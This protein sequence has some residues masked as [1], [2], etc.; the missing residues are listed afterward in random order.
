MSIYDPKKYTRV[1]WIT[2]GSTGIGAETA[3]RLAQDGWVVA[4]SARS[5]DKLVET[6]KRHSN[7]HVFPLDVTKI[8]SVTETIDKIEDQFGDIK[9]AIL[10]AGTYVPDTLEDFNIKNFKKHFDINVIGV[11][12]CVEPLLKKFKERDQGHLAITASIA[13]YHGLP[14]SL[15]YGPTKAA[16]IN[17]TESLK[18]ETKGTNIKVQ[19][20]CPGFVKTPLT[21]QNEFSMPM[22]METDKAAEKL[23]QGLYS[24]KFEI[25]FPWVFCFFVR[26]MSALPY[27]LSIPMMKL[28]KAAKKTK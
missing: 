20:I 8:K 15:S 3:L 17:F 10:N 6:A 7:I 13:G 1:A 28:A 5:E 23:V 18:I 4:I 26:R 16:L 2:G 14:R 9:M 12:N 19:L 27:W 11:A 21:D 25:T 22:L 24:N